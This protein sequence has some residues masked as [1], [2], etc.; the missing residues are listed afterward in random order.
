MNTNQ[1]A[2]NEEISGI[3]S[4]IKKEFDIEIDNKKIITEFCNLFESKLIKRNV[5]LGMS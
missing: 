2:F 3:A 4:S 5:I 1:K